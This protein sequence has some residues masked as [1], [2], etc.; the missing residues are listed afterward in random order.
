MAEATERLR[1]GL[2]VGHAGLRSAG[3]TDP[4]G[5]DVHDGDTVA[6]RAAGDFGVRL[7]G[8]DAPEM[9]S[10]LPGTQGPP[11][12]LDD[13]RWEQA[14]AVAF[15]PGALPLGPR[16]DPALVAHLE[17]QAVVG[18]AVTHARLAAAARIALVDM[19][20][21]DMAAL[22][23]DAA[24]FRLF[25][26]FAGDVV[27]RY[28]RLLGYVRPDQPDVPA[29]QRL[30]SYNERLLAAGWASPYFIWP[31]TSPWRAAPAI[32]DAV[33]APGTAAQA[34]AADPALAA[35]RASVKAARRLRIGLYEAARP[36]RL[37]AFELRMLARRLPPDR[38]L[39]DLGGDGGTLIPPQCYPRV[40]LPED[41]LFIPAE[42][43]P[44]WVERGWQRPRGL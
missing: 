21:K 16:A 42:Y 40:P 32:V 12:A 27:D 3:A 38:W 18:E 2:L 35:A 39:V 5:K 25:L 11:V 17:A 1:S 34:A 22:G 23:V 30:G 24:G 29:E 26:A 10:P 13:P 44:L 8:V 28:G 15:A 43:V 7:L 14:L 33:P 4:V 41:R 9:S 19:V 36:L 37:Q 20:G 31:N 6:V